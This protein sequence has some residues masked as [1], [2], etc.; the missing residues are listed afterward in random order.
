MIAQ[1]VMSNMPIMLENIYTLLGAEDVSGSE[2]RRVRQRFALRLGR[3]YVD[4][5]GIRL[6]LQWI[7]RIRR[8]LGR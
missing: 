5:D 1:A 7:D 3:Y 4:Y 8:T 2:K 6:F